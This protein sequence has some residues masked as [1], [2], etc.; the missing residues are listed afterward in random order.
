MSMFPHTI[1]LYNVSENQ[2]TFQQEVNITV[3]NGVLL[4]ASRAANVRESGMESADAV[5]LYIPFSVEAVDGITLSPK[6]YASPKIYDAEED[7]SGFWTLQNSDCFFVKG[8]VV[9]P[10]RD[11]QY[12]NQNFDDVYRVTSMD[13]KDFGGLKHLEVGGR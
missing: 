13:E 4:D 7:K 8:N 3:L 6:K 1:T 5:N 2:A 9:Q 10:D 12:I 11:F